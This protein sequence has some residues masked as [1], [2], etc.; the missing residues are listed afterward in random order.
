MSTNLHSGMLCAIQNGKVK[1]MSN[2]EQ[3]DRIEAK[4]DQL[5]HVMVALLDVLD[6]GEEFDDGERDQ[7]Q[8]L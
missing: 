4:I 5:N 7:T 2:Q 8:P 6:E 1:A 3:L